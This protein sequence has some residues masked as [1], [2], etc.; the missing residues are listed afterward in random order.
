MQSGLFQNPRC[1]VIIGWQHKHG[2]ADIPVLFEKIMEK[3]F[4]LSDYSSIRIH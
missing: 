3:T 2:L 4:N 1:I